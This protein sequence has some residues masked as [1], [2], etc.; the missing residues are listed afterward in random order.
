MAN[1]FKKQIAAI[2][3][4]TANVEKSSLNQ[5]SVEL[6]GNNS[7][8][9]QRL[10]Q[11]TL[12]DSLINGEITQEVIDLR[13]RMFKVLNAV[14]EL[15]S[16]IT[17]YEEDGTPIVK[18]HKIRAHKNKLTKVMVDKYDD[19]KV[20]IVVDNTEIAEGGLGSIQDV[21]MSVNEGQDLADSVKFNETLSA[22]TATLGNVDNDTYHSSIKA[23]RPILINREFRARFEI[24]K[25]TKKMN[26]RTISE[27][28]KLLEFYV[29]IYPDEYNR[30]SNLFISE[31]KKAIKNPR[32][33]D[34]L[35]IKDIGFTA[36]KTP[37]ARDFHQYLYHVT[38]FDKIIEFDGYYVIKFK[39]DVSVDGEYLLEKYRSETLDERY[40][41][42]EAKN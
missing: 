16:N 26:V 34:F 27:T 24:E 1:W 4:A 39:C 22:D 8:T 12:A 20:E 2:V 38:K 3:I 23:G 7:G 28:E 36:Y 31:I 40:N 21:K 19:Y 25:F 13:W 6:E 29:S 37:G 41:N 32:V 18:T 11:G 5:T 35:D 10:N 14:E 42:K 33:C 15:Q 9:Y 30:K 17:G